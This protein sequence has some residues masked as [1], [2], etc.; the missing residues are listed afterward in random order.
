[1][2]F[3]ASAGHL[4]QFILVQTHP[5]RVLFTSQNDTTTLSSIVVVVLKS[6][7]LEFNCIRCIAARQRY[8]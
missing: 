7:Y 3:L 1:M 4:Q 5:C 6:K 8:W 2:P